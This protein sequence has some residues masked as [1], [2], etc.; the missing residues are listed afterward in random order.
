LTY[1]GKSLR[2]AVSGPTRRA[3]AMPTRRVSDSEF[4]ATLAES[5]QLLSSLEATIN[6][7]AEFTVALREHVDLERRAPRHEP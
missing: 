3:R 7:L 2:T 5:A 4:A 1:F 6:E